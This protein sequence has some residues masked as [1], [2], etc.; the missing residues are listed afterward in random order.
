MPIPQQIL[1]SQGAIVMSEV[2]MDSALPLAQ[3]VERQAS[4]TV[5][6]QA[7]N[8]ITDI[9]KKQAYMLFSRGQILWNDGAGTINFNNSTTASNI[10]FRLMHWD[11]SS[12]VVDLVFVGG[13]TNTTTTFST[14]P[15]ASGELLYLD[16]NRDLIRAGG[17]PITVLNGVSGGA[18]TGAVV[19]RKAVLGTASGMPVL[20]ST[21]DGTT[22]TTA[23]I[24]IVMRDDYTLD[25]VSYAD[26]L[27]IP[28][29]IRWPKGTLSSIGEVVVSGFDALPNYFVTSKAQL[30]TALSALQT[31]GGIICLTQGLTLDQSITVYPNIQ[32]TARSWELAPI[33]IAAGTTITLQTR[34]ELKNLNL[35]ATS[36]FGIGSAEAV[37]H[38]DGVAVR[39]RVTDCQI[40]LQN[41]SGDATCITVAGSQTRI[42]NCQLVGVDAQPLY[43]TGI[44]Y[45]GGS[46]NTDIDT[47]YV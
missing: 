14:L 41:V 30:I 1:D 28:H 38:V 17:N 23:A 4:H 7:F 46:N 31:T 13:A 24:P 5:I 33:T 8:I 3:C 20:L 19:L 35:I 25:A 42:N 16:I 10:I 9:L 26:L 27:W 12:R 43:R 2:A 45:T 40:T 32:V 44:A 15:L 39:A 37:V 21:I 29:G 6:T 47:I 36:Y 11:D 18:T 22:T 34:A